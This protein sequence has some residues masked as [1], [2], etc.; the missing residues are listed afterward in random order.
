MNSYKKRAKGSWNQGKGYKGD[1]EERQF[2]KQEIAQ[3]LAEDEADYLDKYKGKRKRNDRARLEYRVKWYE[4]AIASYS[5][6][7][8]SLSNWF[9]SSLKEAKKDLEELE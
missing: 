6:T 2:S 4:D 8:S 9:R 5:K 1:S 7:N 3:Q